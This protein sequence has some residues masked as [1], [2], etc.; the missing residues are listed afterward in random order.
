MEGHFPCPHFPIQSNTRESCSESSFLCRGSSR[1]GNQFLKIKR[2]NEEKI[3]KREIYW[4]FS[5]FWNLRLSGQN[6]LAKARTHPTEHPMLRCYL[7][8]KRSHTPQKASL[9]IQINLKIQTFGSASKLSYKG[10]FLSNK[11]M[12]QV[13]LGTAWAHTFEFYAPPSIGT[14]QTHVK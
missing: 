2:K 14:H 9:W 10:G 3:F 5:Q 8:H 1:R 11:Y 7:A 13:R 6:S 4:W 12:R